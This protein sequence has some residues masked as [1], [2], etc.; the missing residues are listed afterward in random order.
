M[1]TLLLC[2]GDYCNVLEPLTGEDEEFHRLAGQ[3]HSDFEENPGMANVIFRSH[4]GSC[5]GNKTINNETFFCMTSQT[6]SRSDT[7]PLSKDPVFSLDLLARQ[8]LSKAYK[9]TLL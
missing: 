6:D 3:M 9:I 8:K 7:G 4:G 1:F 5:Y 2:E